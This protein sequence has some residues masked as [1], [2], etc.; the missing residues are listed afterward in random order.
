MCMENKCLLWKIVCTPNIQSGRDFQGVDMQHGDKLVR[1]KQVE[2]MRLSSSH[3]ETGFYPIWDK[4]FIII[5]PTLHQTSPM[6]CALNQ[7]SGQRPKCPFGKRKK[8]TLSEEHDSIFVWGWLRVSVSLD[9]YVIK[10]RGATSALTFLVCECIL[11]K[12]QIEKNENIHPKLQ[13]R[14]R[15]GD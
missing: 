1:F 14:R 4:T 10:H 2:P 9:G 3:S 6:F 5:E 8:K 12:G 13:V 7:T 11:H 15:A